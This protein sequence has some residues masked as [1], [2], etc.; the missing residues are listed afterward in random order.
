MSK[1]EK[2]V[3]I[4]SA[5]T[6]KEQSININKSIT[7]KQQKINLQATENFKNFEQGCWKRLRWKNCMTQFIHQR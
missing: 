1:K 2:I 4:S 5:A 3:P 7:E 6:E